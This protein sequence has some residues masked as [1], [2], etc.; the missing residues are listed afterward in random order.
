MK[1]LTPLEV[2]AIMRLPEHWDRERWVRTRCKTGEIKAKQ[3]SRGVWRINETALAE[4]LAPDETVTVPAESESVTTSILDGL[5]A[6]S[7]RKLAS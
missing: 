6:R 5:S 7:R 2:A 1:L 3:I 4:Y